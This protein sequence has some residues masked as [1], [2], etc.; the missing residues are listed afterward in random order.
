MLYYV[1]DTI[2][3]FI[4]HLISNIIHNISGGWTLGRRKSITSGRSENHEG[5]SK[6]SKKYAEG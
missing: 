5:L 6:E 3:I 4:K 1:I 2:I